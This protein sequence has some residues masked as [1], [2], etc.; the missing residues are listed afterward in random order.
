MWLEHN[1][2][3]KE[4]VEMRPQGKAKPDLRGLVAGGDECVCVCVCVWGGAGR[5]WEARR[6]GH[7][8]REGEGRIL[9]VLASCGQ[10]MTRDSYIFISFKTPLPLP[11]PPPPATALG[12]GD[13]YLYFIKI[14]CEI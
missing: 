2:Q 12:S 10:V 4:W 1:Q 9:C 3:E 14:S 13:Y 5:G 11:S 8:G 6:R 7:E